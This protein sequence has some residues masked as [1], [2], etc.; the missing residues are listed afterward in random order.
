[1]ETAVSKSPAH[2]THME[3]RSPSLNCL[4]LFH[5]QGFQ[6]FNFFRHFLFFDILMYSVRVLLV[7]KNVFLTISYGV[8]RTFTVNSVIL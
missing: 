4:W 1:M 2:V 8:Y 3:Q 6:K 5:K 7:M